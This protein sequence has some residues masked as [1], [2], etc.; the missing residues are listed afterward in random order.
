MRARSGCALMGS[1]G[2]AIAYG[3]LSFSPPSRGEGKPCDSNAEAL[4]FQAATVRT[5]EDLEK[6][7]PL[8][9]KPDGPVILDCK[10]NAA[11]AAPF[12]SEVHEYET[13]QRR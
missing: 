2:R 10:L 6:A 7:R 3:L 9:E 11:V 12:M 1:R 8:L 4:G 5:L 13:R